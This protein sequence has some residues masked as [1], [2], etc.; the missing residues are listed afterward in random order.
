MYIN[1]TWNLVEE[2]KNYR[3]YE[4]TI[5]R[6][7]DA[8]MS[9]A[10]LKDLRR[11]WSTYF[12]S[13]EQ[14]KN[15]LRYASR[16]GLQSVE[17]RP[18]KTEE[19]RFQYRHEFGAALDKY[20]GSDRRLDCSPHARL[21]HLYEEKGKEFVQN[22]FRKTDYYQMFAEFHRVGSSVNWDTGRPE[23]TSFT[24][25]FIEKKVEKFIR[26][27]ENMRTRGY[28]SFPLRNR[29]ICVLEGAYESERFK[30]KLECG[31]YEVW[32]GHHRGAILC[33]LEYEE[34]D[35]HVLRWEESLI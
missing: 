13:R 35:A 30:R 25:E 23:P 31:P 26:L 22:N 11:F 15:D 9:L 28:L 12:R 14:Q 19:I 21:L 8:A 29:R 6:L 17:I 10:Y 34:I 32:S 7:S 2:P 4:S 1:F 33:V 20:L 27:Y 16:C 3:P 24:D 18:V 5:S